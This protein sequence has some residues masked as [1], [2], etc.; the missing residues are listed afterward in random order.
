MLVTF[1]YLIK[2]KKPKSF[3]YLSALCFVLYKQISALLVSVQISNQAPEFKHRAVKLADVLP[4]QTALQVQELIG[5]KTEQGK[6]FYRVRW[7]GYSSAYNTWEPEE[8][9]QDCKEL[10]AK[11]MDKEASKVSEPLKIY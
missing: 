3:T 5:R 11:Y 6:D 1:F 9:L 8:N 7:S 10:I 4:P 2:A